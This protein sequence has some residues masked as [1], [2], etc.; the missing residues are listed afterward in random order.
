MEHGIPAADQF[1]LYQPL[2]AHVRN[3]DHGRQRTKP[4]EDRREEKQNYASVLHQQGRSQA[5]VD[6][7]GNVLIRIIDCPF[8]RMRGQRAL[9]HRFVFALLFLA[10]DNTSA[11]AAR[12][13]DIDPWI[14]NGTKAI[15]AR[16]SVVGG[17]YG[18]GQVSPERS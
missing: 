18:N 16:K 12:A 5:M 6:F 17:R 11:F 7:T 15:V 3:S 2:H 14:S 1:G 8:R 13:I 9:L 10:V 4:Q